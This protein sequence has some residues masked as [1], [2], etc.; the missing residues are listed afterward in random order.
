MTRLLL[1]LLLLLLL[2]LLLLRSLYLSAQSM[3]PN[4]LLFAC[5]VQGATAGVE[6]AARLT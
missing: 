3:L 4:E 6:R 1:L 5:G 2:V